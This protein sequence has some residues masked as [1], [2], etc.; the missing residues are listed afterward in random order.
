M[1]KNKF[2]FFLTWLLLATFFK[3]MIWSGLVPLWHFPDEQ[4]HFAQ[5]QNIVE[6]KRIYPKI[7]PTTSFEIFNSEMLLGT[8]RDQKGNNSFTFKPEYNLPYTN[9]YTGEVELKIKHMDISAR[10][11]MV[12]D[13]ATSY[14]FLYYL[15]GGVFYVFGFLNNLFVRVFLV[16]LFSVLL[17]CLTTLIAY[18][19][20]KLI[21]SSS[22]TAGVLA[23]MV[24]FQPMFS[25]VGS[26]VNSDVLFNFFFTWFIFTS[27]KIL[28]GDL[29]SFFWLVLSL[30][31]GLLTKQQMIIAVV[32]SLLLLLQLFFK[33]IKQ[34]AYGNFK[35]YLPILFIT[36]ILLPLAFYF[37]EIRRIFGYIKAGEDTTLNNLGIIDHFIWT[38]KHTVAEVL[39][40]YWGV[41]KWLGITL[42]RWVNKIQMRLL[43]LTSIGLIVWIFKKTF[44]RKFKLQDKKIF[45]LILVSGGYFLAVTL[46]DWQFR[47]AYGF[48]FGIQG[49]YFFPTIVAHMALILFGLMQLVPK[50]FENWLAIGLSF[51]WVGLNFI[52]MWTVLNAYY[53]TNTLKKVLWQVSQYKPFWLKADWWYLWVGFY[54]LSLVF[55]MFLLLSKFKKSKNEKILA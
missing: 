22:V 37:G 7:T 15:T 19:I 47:K 41:F 33:N 29:K 35:K 6:E 12:L 27:L 46:W 9:S 36:I 4:A 49:R 2:P 1:I 43:A 51:W 52:G 34:R 44:K 8:L 48:S 53:Q 13:E 18:K 26:G 5:L 25:F 30:V 40:W 24:S 11:K 20:G 31:G 28:S 3:G 38:A 32:L 55:F 10:R 21:F 14:P 39:P 17:T 45:W 50:R 42:P 23:I 54:L 16:R